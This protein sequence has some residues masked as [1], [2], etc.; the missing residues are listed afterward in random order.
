M[1]HT[2]PQS[3]PEAAPAN[4][5][6][7]LIFWTSAASRQLR[8]CLASLANSAGISDG[9]LL[10]LWLCLGEEGGLVQGDLAAS[11]GVSPA[12]MSG[13]VERLRQRGLIEMHRQA[14]DRRRQVWRGTAAAR[15]VL[16]SL[17]VALANL[18]DHL[19]AQLT[20]D[21]QQTALA[22][23]QRLAAAAEAW[24]AG[25]DGNSLGN[26]ADGSIAGSTRKAA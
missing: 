22:L 26:L 5:L 3:T 13:I 21:E 19:S 7:R 1:E 12:Q 9:E 16:E 11:L 2:I 23:G 4:R 18:A 17:T 25:I 10:T 14:L 20:P 15:Q 8:R 6:L 24:P